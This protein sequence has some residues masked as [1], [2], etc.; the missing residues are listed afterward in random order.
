MNYTLTISRYGRHIRFD[1]LEELREELSRYFTPREIASG[2]VDRL[3]T[4]RKPTARDEENGYIKNS[5]RDF[6]VCYYLPFTEC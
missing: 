4:F 5:Y 2:F 6:D 3:S 1:T